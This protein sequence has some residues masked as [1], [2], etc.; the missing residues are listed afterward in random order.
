MLSKARER[1]AD[2]LIVDLEDAVA[3]A[4]K[5]EALEITASWVAEGHLG[6]P[7]VWVRV[8]NH[9]D[10]IDTEIRSVVGPHLTGIMVP[11]IESAADM[12]A[13]AAIVSDAEQLAGLSSGSIRMMAF[14]ET[15]AAVLAVDGILGVDGVDGIVLGE[16]DLSAELAVRLSPNEREFLPFRMQMIVACAAAGLDP[17]VGPVHTDFRDLDA[18]R[19]STEALAR[20]G[21]MSRQA[22]HPAQ[23]PVINDVFTPDLEQVERARRLVE[24]ADSAMARGDG[25]FLDD[26]GRLVDEAILRSARR[27]VEVAERALDVGASE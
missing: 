24:A 25:V 5:S 22:I 26:D 9:P 21:F 15:A 19:R 27:I 17:P 20:M 2:A 16:A 18:L 11:K 12:A 8:N 4:S 6:G 1:G 13:A 23:V 3:P 7:P 14:I 10:L